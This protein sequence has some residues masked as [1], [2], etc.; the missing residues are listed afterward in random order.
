MAGRGFPLLHNSSIYTDFLM[1]LLQTRVMRNM[2]IT[3]ISAFDKIVRLCP[4]KTRTSLPPGFP[5]SSFLK[6]ST[7]Y[8]S[9]QSTRGGRVDDMRTS[10][11]SY[12]VTHESESSSAPAPFSSDSSSSCSLLRSSSRPVAI[13]NWLWPRSSQS[14]EHSGFG[15][16]LPAPEA[17][18]SVK[19]SRRPSFSTYKR[20]RI[21]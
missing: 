21:S 19:L 2:F 17:G 12:L 16:V 20:E 14:A 6:L 8:A 9:A 13:A 3:E 5:R 1:K 11:F 4:I 7:V 15:Q 18:D 10:K